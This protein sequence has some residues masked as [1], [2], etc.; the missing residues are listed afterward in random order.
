[1]KIIMK[2]KSL[3]SAGLLAVLTLFGSKKINSRPENYMIKPDSKTLY[4][5]KMNSIEGKEIDFSQYR[6][7]KVLIVNVA[8]ECGFTPQYEGLEKLYETYKDKLVVLG[9]PANNF[10]GQEPGSN[11]AIKSFCRD[12]YNVTFP[13]FEK[14]SVIGSD[15]HPLYQWLTQKELNG[16]NDKPPTWNFCKYLID[17]TGNLIKFYPSAVEPMSDEI[18]SQLK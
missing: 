2:V 7:K 13:M 9:F 8:S 14:I 12:N 17:E 1:M 6:G 4:E 5:F 15:Q 3:F 10:G 18:T 11:E 16:W